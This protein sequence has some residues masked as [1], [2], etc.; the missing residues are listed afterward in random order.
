[1]GYW[2]WDSA[3]SVGIAVI[4]DQHKRIIEYISELNT[5]S[6]YLNHDKEKVRT[7]IL[8]LLD[9]TMSHLAFEERLMEEAGYRKLEAHKQI[10]LALMERIYFFKERYESGEDIAQ[11]LML[12]LQ[13]WL[14]NHIQHDDTDYK[15]AVQAM[16]HKREIAPMEEHI[17]DGWLT[18]L[19]DK[20]FK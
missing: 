5:V 19:R 16:L 4:D 8:A 10:H 2:R 18:T 15:E 7:V 14:I 11:Q 1:M 13:M 17:K 6:M 20:F 3:F 9:Y 12:E